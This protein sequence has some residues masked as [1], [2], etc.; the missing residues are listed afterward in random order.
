MGRSYRSIR[1]RAGWTRLR[2]PQ[3][4]DGGDAL[5]AEQFGDVGGEG[6]RDASR[7]RLIAAQRRRDGL[8]P[9]PV[10]PRYLV[11]GLFEQA[12]TSCL[13]AL[14][15]DVE[16]LGLS[17]AN[18]KKDY[19]GKQLA[20]WLAQIAY[21]TLKTSKPI[22]IGTGAEDTTP[23]AATQVKLMQDACNAGSVVEGHL[24]KGL[25]HSATVNASLKDS[26][27]FAHKV[28]NDQP[29]TPICAPT[30]Q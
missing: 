28:I 18:T 9:G 26:I 15:G 7:Q 14:E 16:G 12:R 6:R 24:Y 13:F 2:R 20:P 30:A 25:G 29:I 3:A 19:K 10:A 1:I 27:P 17:I 4:T 22:F 21:P 11:R 8:E 23:A 5:G